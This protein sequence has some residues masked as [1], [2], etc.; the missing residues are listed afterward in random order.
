MG[1]SR[2]SHS[3]P[4]DFVEEV[5]GGL[6]GSRNRWR[7]DHAEE[8]IGVIGK[9]AVVSSL[10]ATTDV[11]MRIPNRSKLLESACRSSRELG[12][13]EGAYQLSPFLLLY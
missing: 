10:V 11:P 8:N 7:T 5:C 4:D 6:G 3:L 1:R 9:H 2:I 12:L 13:R